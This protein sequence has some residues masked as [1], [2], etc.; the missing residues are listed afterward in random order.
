MDGDDVGAMKNLSV[1]YSQL[2]AGREG[3]PV[4]RVNVIRASDR[5]LV[6]VHL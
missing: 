4:M 2:R 1:L 6:D 3:P 5:E